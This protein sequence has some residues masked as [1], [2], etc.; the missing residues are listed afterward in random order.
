MKWLAHRLAA[1][2]PLMAA[3]G[4]QGAPAPAATATTTAAAPARLT[5]EHFARP[6]QIGAVRVNPAGTHFAMLL[7]GENGRRIAA[8]ASLDKP[9]DLKPVAAF[10]DANVDEVYWVNDRRLVYFGAKTGYL[11]E[12]GGAG[13]FAID[14]DGGEQRQLVA[15]ADT[16]EQ[17][18]TRIQS[19]ILPYGWFLQATLDDGSD[20][21]LM[22]RP[23]TDAVGE[24]S[25]GQL[26]RLNTR[27]GALRTINVGAPSSASNWLLDPQGELRVVR[28]SVNGR[29]RL[30][31]RAP[32][33]KDWTLIDDRPSNAEDEL[34]PLALESPE[35]LLVMTRNGQDTAALYSYDLRQRR[36]DPE[37]V[38][39]LAGFDIDPELVLNRRT[40]A[41]MGLHTRAAQPVSV[42]FD[43][44]LAQV[45]QQVN[46]ALPGDRFNRLVCGRCDSN[47]RF[48]VVSKSDRN[49]GEL[50][51]FDPKA[52]RLVRMG[53]MRPWLEEA[54][55]G[56]RTFH[57]VAARDGL[58]LP[59][60]LTHPAGS[61]KAE[62]LPA[63]MLVH[64][65]PW[66]RG[67][68][69]LWREEAQFL[70]SRGLRVIEVEFRG[71]TGFGWRHFRAGWKEWGQAMQDDLADALAWAAKEGWVDP[72]RACIY[73]ASYGGYAALMGPIRHPQAWR[74]A[75]SFVGVTD[76]ELLYN[77]TWGDLSKQF[78]RHGLPALVGD[79]QAD[80]ERL[81]S[82]SPLR[83]VAEIK[84]PVLLAQGIHDRRV[85]KE[86]ADRF[87]SAARSTGVRVERVNYE[88]GH[89]WTEAANHA[90]FLRRLD[91]FV[92]QSLQAP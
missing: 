78:K 69:R 12:Q 79:L 66:V 3:L 36:L 15:W 61:D 20:D 60:V 16:T 89:G 38:A 23:A 64:G 2:L 26:A 51:L 41:L 80:A 30:H 35:H 27:T 50:Y 92:Q 29:D 52:A 73:G 63:V 39:A 71:S 33:G 74:C 59:V 85:P 67:S 11:V 65:G 13:F 44:R 62:P 84:V 90:D 49:P 4:V 83:R 37:P 18:G 45:Q 19:R 68:D 25:A 54:S 8:V 14:L 81:R 5:A 76:L 53:T 70:A 43:E 72:N 77:A 40:G 58:S 32:G 10:A 6:P 88:E 24:V 82:S 17:A 91:A 47:E 21:V 22:H 48:I 87:V 31:W 56:R 46:A 34:V 7:T 1:A 86:H 75:A 42:W 57:R 9:G 55:Q 28:V